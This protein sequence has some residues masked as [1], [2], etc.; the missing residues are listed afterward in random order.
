LT[1]TVRAQHSKILKSIIGVDS[2]Y[3]IDLN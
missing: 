2:V 3:M 1:M